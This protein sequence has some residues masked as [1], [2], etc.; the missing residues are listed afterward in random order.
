MREAS[1]SGSERLSLCRFMGQFDRVGVLI[2]RVFLFVVDADVGGTAG[3]GLSDPVDAGPRRR[4][5][6]HAAGRNAAVA[7]G[8][9]VGRPLAPV[10]Q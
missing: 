4:Y 1:Q 7:A 10:A 2:T 9:P 3:I 6:E 8:P 5:H